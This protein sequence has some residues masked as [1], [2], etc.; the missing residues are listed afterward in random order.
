MKRVLYAIALVAAGVLAFWIVLCREAQ[1]IS[2][3]EGECI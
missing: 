2:F 1:C 3:M